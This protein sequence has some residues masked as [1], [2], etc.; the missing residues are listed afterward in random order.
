MRHFYRSINATGFSSYASVSGPEQWR[1]IVRPCMIGLLFKLLNSTTV[2]VKTMAYHVIE[3][4]VLEQAPD[5]EQRSTAS[6]SGDPQDNYHEG[7]HPT[8][9]ER[10]HYELRPS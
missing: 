4:E 3:Y 10:H 1:T 2:L 5:G 8:A 6:H 9:V 7:C